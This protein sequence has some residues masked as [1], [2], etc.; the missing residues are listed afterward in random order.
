MENNTNYVNKDEL[1]GAAVALDV[2]QYIIQDL[3]ED[4]FDCYD[5][6][7]DDDKYKILWEYNRNRAKMAA[8]SMLI[9]EISQAFKLN[10]IDCYLSA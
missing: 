5:S 4:F 1:V 2:A 3:Q 6:S 8:L 9:Y 10:K 7:S